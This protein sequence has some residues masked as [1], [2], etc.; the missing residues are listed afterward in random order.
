MCCRAC[1]TLGSRRQCKLR[2]EV[3][4]QQNPQTKHPAH[5]VLHHSTRSEPHDAHHACCSYNC[6][7]APRSARGDCHCCPCSV[8]HGRQPEGISAI[9]EC[10]CTAQLR[11]VPHTAWNRLAQGDNIKFFKIYRWDPD[12]PGQKPYTASYPVNMDECVTLV[13]RRNTTQHH[14]TMLRRPLPLRLQ[15]WPH[16]A[17]CPHQDQ[18]RTGPHPDL[19]AV[20]VR[21]TRRCASLH[22]ASQRWCHMPRRPP[23]SQLLP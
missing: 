7:D 16:A 12:V 4:R 9:C 15:M 6:G 21:F 3:S 5:T 23:P 13:V 11:R 17:G 20:R 2:A 18:E 22:L 19:P 8:R 14:C 10:G 1:P